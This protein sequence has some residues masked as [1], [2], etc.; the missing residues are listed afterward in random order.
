MTGIQTTWQ[1]LKPRD[2]NLNHVEEEIAA[3]TFNAFEY[4]ILIA[5]GCY[6]PKCQLSES[7]T[8]EDKNSTAFSDISLAWYSHE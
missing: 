2:R 6:S 3:K 1:E 7:F 5:A 8:Q 4:E